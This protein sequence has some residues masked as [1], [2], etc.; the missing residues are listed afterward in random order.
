MSS[1][2]ILFGA[3]R[4]KVLMRPSV[5][6]RQNKSSF[7]LWY[8]VSKK[9]Y[10]G[11]G[12]HHI[13]FILALSIFYWKTILRISLIC[14]LSY[15]FLKL[16][17]LITKYIR[18]IKMHLLNYIIKSTTRKQPWLTIYISWY[19]SLN[20]YVINLK[21]FSFKICELDRMQNSI[22]FRLIPQNLLN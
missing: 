10:A 13:K 8:F 18:P 16:G 6:K 15:F 9:I 11:Y 7:F 20:K 4:V 5:P 21:L 2:A 14:A 22:G 17:I 12:W 3:L 1:A 19:L